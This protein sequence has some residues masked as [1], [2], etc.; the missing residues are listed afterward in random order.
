MILKDEFS[1]LIIRLRLAPDVAAHIRWM[2]E[3]FGVG[4]TATYFFL[5]KRTVRIIKTGV[6]RGLYDFGYFCEGYKIR[7]HDYERWTARLRRT[8]PD[9][10]LVR[11]MTHTRRNSENKKR[12]HT[13]RVRTTDTFR[14]SYKTFSETGLLVEDDS[15]VEFR[16]RMQAAAGI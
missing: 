8:Y 11:T 2:C 4:Q 13:R 9:F 5:D 6:D 7:L 14:N 15:V 3:E 10:P 16:N 1:N 12:I